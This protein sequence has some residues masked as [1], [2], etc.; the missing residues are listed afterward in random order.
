MATVTASPPSI[1]DSVK[2]PRQRDAW[3]GGAWHKPAQGRYAERAS[4]GTGE[5]LGQVAECGAAD[6]DAAV[7]AAR[8]AFKEWRR[9]PPLERAR[10]LRRVAQILRE[11][12]GELAM[13]DAADC[14]NPVK[15]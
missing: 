8:A 5:S 6:I 2:L 3:Y 13:I 7:R 11:N 12:A 15:E 4:P 1:P 14:G 10:I 9:V